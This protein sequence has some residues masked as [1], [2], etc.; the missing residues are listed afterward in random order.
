[1]WKRGST[2]YSPLGIL[3]SSTKICSLVELKKATPSIGDPRLSSSR[4]ASVDEVGD[5][6]N[7][8]YN[9]ITSGGIWLGIWAWDGGVSLLSLGGVGG[10]V[11]IELLPLAMNLPLES[12]SLRISYFFE[13]KRQIYLITLPRQ[14]HQNF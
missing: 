9:L 13:C 11:G 12:L 4:A 14:R 5:P 8:I 3:N 6:L 7:W 10:V 2:Y 1:M